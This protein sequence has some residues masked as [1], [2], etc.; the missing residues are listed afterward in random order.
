MSVGFALLG[1]GLLFLLDGA[2]AHSKVY[3]STPQF[4]VWATLTIVMIVSL[5]VV[6]RVGADLLALLGV[7]LRRELLHSWFGP[8]SICVIL[9]VAAAAFSAGR[10]A[11]GAG[12]PFYGGGLRITVIYVLVLGAAVPAALVMRECYRQAGDDGG[13]HAQN[14]DVR[15]THLLVLRQCLLSA[16]TTLGFLV[17]LG[18]LVTGAERQAALAAPKLTSPYPSAY[19]L[20]WGLSFSALLLVIFVPGFRRLT[21]LANTTIETLLPLLT[22]SSEGW[23][24]RL[25]ERKDLAELLKVTSGAKDVITSAVLVAG[26]LI[27]SAF[28]LFLPSGSG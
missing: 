26:P 13:T 28:S 23:Q 12:S 21:N 3:T 9:A 11:R 14:A 8:V 2:T 1:T 24:A 17:S 4:K 20:I 16:L 7:D 6:W 5:P 15:I 22:P 10:I 25:Q 19:V 27:S 18:V